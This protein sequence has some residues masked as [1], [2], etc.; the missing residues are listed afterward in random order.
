MSWTP[1]TLAMAQKLY[2]ACC[3]LPLIAAVTGMTHG[4]VRS[5]FKRLRNNGDPEFYFSELVRQLALKGGAR[6][7]TLDDLR[8]LKDQPG[9]MAGLNRALAPKPEEEAM[10]QRDPMGQAQE[11]LDEMEK[12]AAPAR[13]T[14]GPPA[15]IGRIVMYRLSGHDAESIKAQ[16]VGEYHGNE[17]YAGEVY[18][19]VVVKT[20]G[21]DAT[22]AVNLR[23]L[24]DGDDVYWATSRTQGDGPFEWSWPKIVGA[25]PPKAREPEPQDQE[26][27]AS[28]AA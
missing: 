8:A 1:G 5:K 9:F 7:V 20:W 16:R 15:T 27:P 11:T 22:S 28:Q 6:L 10:E 3:S 24:L 4:A 12:E 17:A 25:P 14:L 18:P 19:A 23:V 26:R 13:D 2:A 21:D